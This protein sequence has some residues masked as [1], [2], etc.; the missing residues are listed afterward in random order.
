VA[1]D[2]QAFA[3]NPSIK[4]LAILD[5]FGPTDLATIVNEMETDHGRQVQEDAVQRLLGGPLS[6]RTDL[7]RVASPL[8]Y[9]KPGAPPVLILQGD[10]DDL[11]SYVQSQRLHS[12]LD[13]TGVKN[14]LLT[15]TGAGHDGPKFETLDVQKRVLNFLHQILLP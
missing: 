2:E 8:Q 10:Q 6:T 3:A 4:P 12:L 11:V 1:R 7:A 14:E 13:Q 9:V 15:V 5:F